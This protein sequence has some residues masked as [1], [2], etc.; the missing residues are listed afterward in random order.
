MS[1]TIT[2]AARFRPSRSKSESK[3]DTTTA[4]ARAILDDEVSRREAK[5]A[6]LRAARLAVEEI[7]AAA[8][9][10]AKPAKTTA[11]RKPAAKQVAAKKAVAAKTK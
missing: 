5:T 9:A 11:A 1:D 2:E 6:K 4:V 10:A 7:D 8:A 3:A